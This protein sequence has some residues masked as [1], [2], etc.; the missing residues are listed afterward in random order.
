MPDRLSSKHK[1]RN[2]NTV[3]YDTQ[4]DI[5]FQIYGLRVVVVKKGGNICRTWINSQQQTFTY[6]S[7]W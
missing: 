5:K 4:G 7:H 3:A 1:L 2:M 6:C